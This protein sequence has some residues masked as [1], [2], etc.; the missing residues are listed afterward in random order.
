MK[1]FEICKNEYEKL[2]KDNS[3]LKA[4]IQ[5][6]N[7]EIESLNQ[8]INEQKDKIENMESMLLTNEKQINY[9][10]TINS[11]NVQTQKDH[12]NLIEQLKATIENLQKTN[13]NHF[14]NITELN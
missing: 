12:E 3:E 2:T 6:R 13:S 4:F 14:S 1:N 5:I 10:N 9:L 8:T 11:S 7:K